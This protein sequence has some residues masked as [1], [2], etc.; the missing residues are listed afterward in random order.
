M[1]DYVVINDRSPLRLHLIKNPR[2]V[3]VNKEDKAAELLI[4]RRLD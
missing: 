4:F 2:Y 1:F 3:R